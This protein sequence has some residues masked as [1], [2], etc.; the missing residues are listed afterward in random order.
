MKHEMRLRSR[1]KF[2]RTFTAGIVNRP[3]LTRSSADP[4]D[5]RALTP[6]QF[7]LPS[8]SVVG[9]SSILPAEPL[10]GSSLRRSHDTLRPIVDELWLRFQT[11]YVVTF[12]RLVFT[13]PR[14]VSLVLVFVLLTLD[15]VSLSPTHN[16]QI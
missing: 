9:S 8:N 7:I 15:I 6:A 11:E 10:S 16:G 3:P 13:F 4:K 1:N 12:P 14:L 2:A 5:L